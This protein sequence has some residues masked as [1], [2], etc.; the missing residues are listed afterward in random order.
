MAALATLKGM[1]CQTE[2]RLRMPRTEP[3]H[4]HPATLCFV[5][6]A[7]IRELFGSLH[8]LFN[9]QMRALRD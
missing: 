6:L 2:E 1:H 5:P 3:K 8:Q 9:V 7:R 4:F